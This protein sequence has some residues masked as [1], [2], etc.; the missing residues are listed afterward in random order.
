MKLKSLLLSLIVAAFVSAVP[1]LAEGTVDINTATIEQLAEVKGIGP[2]TATAIVE[3]RE[4]NGAFHSVD[5]LVNVKGIGDKKLAA[6]RDE[7]TVGGH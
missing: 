3:H 5:D 7:L 2:K 4:A 6:I 1:A